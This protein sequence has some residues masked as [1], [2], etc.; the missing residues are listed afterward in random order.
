M[1]DNPTYMILF[2]EIN[3]QIM[4]KEESNYQGKYGR[5]HSLFYYDFIRV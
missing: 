1:F 4:K 2:A 3:F 5:K